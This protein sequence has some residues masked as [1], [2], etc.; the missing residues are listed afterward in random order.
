M[1]RGNGL[2]LF[3][4]S[5]ELG[6]KGL[7]AAPQCREIG[8]QLYALAF[9]VRFDLLAFP[10][11]V[12]FQLLAPEFQLAGYRGQ[13]SLP[14]LGLFRFPPMRCRDGRMFVL[15]GLLPDLPV[16]ELFVEFFAL[17]GQRLTV[18]FERGLV[19]RHLGGPF[20]DQVVFELV[21]AE[22][23][24]VAPGL[25]LREAAIE[26]AVLFGEYAFLFE[27]LGFP[28]GAFGFQLTPHFLNC[29]GCIL[30]ELSI[31]ISVLFPAVFQSVDVVE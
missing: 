17:A 7:L 14:P 13:F 27:P 30:I 21:S 9:E 6:F 16:C 18:F 12:G 29:L 5:L 19:V 31:G 24:F 8:L 26:L 10:C 22:R 4:H 23:Q 20:G 3:R 15:S 28:S 2:I 25:N 11:D 1:L